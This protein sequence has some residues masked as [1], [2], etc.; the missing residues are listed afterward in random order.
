MSRAPVASDPRGDPPE[1][2]VGPGPQDERGAASP[3]HHGAR[4]HLVAATARHRDRLPGHRRLVQLQPVGL[5]Q[6]RVRGHDV[7]GVQPHE[8]AGH[9]LAAVDPHRLPVAH[10]RGVGCRH[11]V[12]GRRWRWPPAPPGR[13]RWS[14]F[15]TTTATMM[16]ASEASPRAR[17]TPR[18]PSSSRIIGS[19]S[20]FRTRD[21]RPG[22]G[23]RGGR[24]QPYCSSRACASVR[25]RPVGP[26]DE[27]RVT[28]RTVRRGRPTPRAGHRWRPGC[29]GA[30]RPGRCSARCPA[31]PD[32]WHPGARC[33]APGGADASAP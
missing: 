30:G 27:A 33:P 24:F 3:G 13:P 2:A 14:V 15:S 28:A 1:P 18:A 11:R 12:Q 29:P 19:R 32:R 10:H 8:V 9:H 6:L 26:A 22:R 25:V 21:P 31:P 16:T 17:T 23:G 5:D 7:P 4:Q 20:C